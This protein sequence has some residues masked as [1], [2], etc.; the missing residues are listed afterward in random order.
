MG[1]PSARGCSP[2]GMS[3]VDFARKGGVRMLVAALVLLL[4]S[5][6]V[7]SFAPVFLS[8]AESSALTWLLG[9]AG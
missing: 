1:E 9:Q 2:I 3:I 6:C 5:G 7:S 4:C 8:L